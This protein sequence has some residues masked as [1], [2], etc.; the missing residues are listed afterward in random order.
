[1]RE[2]TMSS[3]SGTKPVSLSCFNDG[4]TRRSSRG[5]VYRYPALLSLEMIHETLGQWTFAI[6]ITTLLQVRSDSKRQFS[7]QL[8]V[9]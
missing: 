1:M 4:G 9:A 5:I 3:F 6:S 7:T 8:S 2:Q